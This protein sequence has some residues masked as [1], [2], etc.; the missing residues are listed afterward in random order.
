MRLLIAMME[1]DRAQSL[2][3]LLYAKDER[4][5]VAMAE[6]GL[7]ALNALLEESWDMA[8]LNACL[9]GLNG[10]EVLRALCSRELVCPP[11]ILFLCERDMLPPGII[12]DCV[13]P[14]MTSDDKLCALL[15]I[16]NQKPL[17]ALAAVNAPRI[18]RATEDFL[19]LLAMN[20]ALKGRVYSRWLLCRC[21]PSP[22]LE[23]LPLNALYAACA[24][25]NATTAAAVER[26]LRVAV[27]GVFTQGSIA[28][29]ERCF[30]ATVDSERGKPTNRAFLLQAAQQI[31]L[32]L[33]GAA[34]GEQ[35]RNT[36]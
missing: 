34:L 13:A 2:R 10:G 24:K 16:L 11:R 35:Q 4:W 18:E 30:G 15:S 5:E 31:R 33:R 6:N 9:P 29:I 17:P 21:V 32:I 8:V 25:A 36:P 23:R 26:C 3:S 20:P 1:Q 27:E 28:G 12:P 19:D 14:L 22:R 7:Q